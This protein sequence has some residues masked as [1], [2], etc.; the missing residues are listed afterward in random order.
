MAVGDCSL[1]D[2]DVEPF[3]STHMSGVLT[4]KQNKPPQ[5]DKYVYVLSHTQSLDSHFLCLHVH[6][7]T[8]M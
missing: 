3:E 6:S 8:C 5:K 7:C 2:A 1:W 4:G